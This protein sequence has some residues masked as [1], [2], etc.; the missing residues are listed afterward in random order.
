MA[1][2]KPM[3][4]NHQPLLKS[5]QARTMGQQLLGGDK[6]KCTQ[7]HRK[8]AFSIERIGFHE[9]I[10]IDARILTPSEY[11][12]LIVHCTNI[13]RKRATYSATVTID[14]ETSK[15]VGFNS[16]FSSVKRKPPPLK[17]NTRRYTIP[18]MEFF[19]DKWCLPAVHTGLI[20]P[21][22]TMD[23]AIQLFQRRH[24]GSAHQFFDIAERARSFEN[25]KAGN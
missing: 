7:L 11:D 19:G 23:E 25:E 1:D 4:A 13:T 6:I 15:V 9:L 22:K 16:P 3:A 24:K 5:P 17:P 12:T 20:Y 10:L 14:T 2:I 18:I 8:G 21:G